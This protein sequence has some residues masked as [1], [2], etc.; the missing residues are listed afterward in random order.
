MP[1]IHGDHLYGKRIGVEAHQ[2]VK[3]I[4]HGKTVFA[5]GNPYSDFI[6]GINQIKFIN[7]LSIRSINVCCTVECFM[8]VTPC[9]ILSPIIS[10]ATASFIP[11]IKPCPPAELL[12]TDS[13]RNSSPISGPS[14]SLCKGRPLR[15]RPFRL[16][17]PR[18]YGRDL[19]HNTWVLLQNLVADTYRRSDSM[20]PHSY[21]SLQLVPTS[22]TIR[23]KTSA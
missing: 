4:E 22:G 19:T 6:A 18:I 1:Q 23:R 3:G 8:T 16:Y 15:W 7:S 10:S 11:A 20:P 12:R 17:E 9:D 5:S 14:A 13:S 21:P 2:S